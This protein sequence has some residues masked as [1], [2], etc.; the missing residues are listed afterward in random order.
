M[1]FETIKGTLRRLR[2]GP[3]TPQ[4]RYCEL[5]PSKVA[6]PTFVKVGANDGVTGDPVSDLLLADKR[7][8]G[9][10]IEPVPE[11]F[12]RLAHNF[13]DPERFTLEQ[14]AIGKEEGTAIFYH[15]R[16]DAGV[17]LEGIP[18]WFD[19]LGS[20]DR[21]HILKHLDGRLEPYIVESRIRVSTLAEILRR[22]TLREIHLL[23]VDVEGY[24]FEVLKTVDFANMRPEGI[25]I[26]Y[27]HLSGAD[28]SSMLAL[29]R[30][31]GYRVQDLAG[32]FFAV[33]RNSVLRWV[34]RDS[35]K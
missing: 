6:R 18:S 7:W 8:R 15:V 3:A 9:L 1:L 24:D 25:L 21:N 16:Q 14:V 35:A 17:Q 10:L 11:C 12:E 22:R 27:K 33:H 26:E 5:L 31:S 20:F 34:V 23:H 29:L 13:S 30:R 28:R 19:Q 4:R 2:S 32:D